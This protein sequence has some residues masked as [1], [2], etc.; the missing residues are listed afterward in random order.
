MVQRD[1][2]KVSTG[3]EICKHQSKSQQ[4]TVRKHKN[5]HSKT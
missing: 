4:K 1:M 2:Q 3:T 5:I